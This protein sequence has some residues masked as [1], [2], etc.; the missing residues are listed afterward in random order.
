M[1]LRAYSINIVS[2]PFDNVSLIRAI[3]LSVEKSF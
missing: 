1:S 3:V 2:P